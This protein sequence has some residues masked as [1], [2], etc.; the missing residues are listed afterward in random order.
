MVLASGVLGGSVVSSAGAVDMGGA[1]SEVVGSAVVDTSLGVSSCEAD[2]S[3]TIVCFLG[4]AT[5]HDGAPQAAEV[6]S[7]NFL[8][9]PKRLSDEKK[10]A[11]LFNAHASLCACRRSWL[12]FVRLFPL[13]AGQ[14]SHDSQ[15]PT[16]GRRA[17]PLSR[18][19][20]LMHNT[21]S[22]LCRQD[23]GAVNATM[24]SG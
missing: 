11:T 23:R 15:Q 19:R 20:S 22:T 2:M 24:N 16:V 9:F 14:P 3:S 1:T 13:C 17:S 18:E 12:L 6:L 10:L 5:T 7:S 8:Q 4:C 21:S